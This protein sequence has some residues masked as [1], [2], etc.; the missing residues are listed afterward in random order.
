MSMFEAATNFCAALGAFVGVIVSMAQAH[1]GNYQAA[2]YNILM[3]LVMILLTRR[4]R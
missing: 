4:P 2:T 3:A 1:Q